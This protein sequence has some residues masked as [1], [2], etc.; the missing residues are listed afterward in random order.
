MPQKSKVLFTG[1][2]YV[3]TR[4]ATGGKLKLHLVYIMPETEEVDEDGKR[5]RKQHRQRKTMDLWLWNKKGLSPVETEHNRRIK[6]MAKIAREEAE[7]SFLNTEHG[8]ISPSE[9]SKINFYEW[10]EDYIAEY[11]KAD[12]HVLKLSLKKFRE[13]IEGSKK[14]NM[15]KNAIKPDQLTPNVVRGYVEALEEHCQGEG[16]KTLYKRFKKAV[17]AATREHIFKENPCDGITAKVDDDGLLKKE[18]LTAEEITQLMQCHFDRQSDDVR[19]AFIFCLFTG[20]RF[21]DVKALRY[22]NIDRVGHNVRFQQAKTK[23]TNVVPLRADL[24][25]M[26]GEGEPNQLIF[27][28][29]SPA[30]CNKSLRNWVAK[31]GIQKHISWHC[32]RHTFGANTYKNLKDLRA[33]SELLGHADTKTT[34]IYTQVFDERKREIVDSL[35]AIEQ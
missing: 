31:A 21:C 9:R 29:G 16:A 1:N 33:T 3:E 7:K 27:H 5:H 17:T 8:Y 14:Y 2:P 32:A 22:N 25:A 26:I 23:R 4:E 15:F 13:Y 19:R 34:Q 12:I 6:E 35:P 11:K 18:V 30:A 28:L 24:L 10:F 20:L